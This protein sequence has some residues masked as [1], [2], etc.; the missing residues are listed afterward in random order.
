MFD[1]LDTR[2]ADIV[3]SAITEGRVFCRVQGIHSTINVDCILYG[4]CLAALQGR[5]GRIHSAFDFIPALEAIHE[6]PLI[7]QYM[8]NQILDRLEHDDDAVLGCNLSADNFNNQD[9]LAGV[10]KQ[11]Q[12]RPRLAQRLVL[13]LTETQ[14]LRSLSLSARAIMDLRSLG[15]RLALDDFGA[16]F[17]SPRL[18]Q[19]IDFD[20]V[21]I[22]KAFIHDIRQSAIGFNSLNHMVGL[23]S[24]FAPIVVVEGVETKVQYDAVLAAGATHAQGYFFSMPTAYSTVARNHAKVS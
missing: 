18:L 12:S 21:K 7:D 9:I 16:G 17:A 23:A 20:I 15:C 8:L 19:L 14:A 24:S 3:Q 4:E 5:D 6:T 22:D 13:E 2:Y 1:N 11:I 10:L